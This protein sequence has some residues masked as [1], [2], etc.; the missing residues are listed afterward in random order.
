MLVKCLVFNGQRGF[1]RLA[2]PILQ[3]ILSV[4]WRQ[5]HF[6]FREYLREVVAL[7]YRKQQLSGLKAMGSRIVICIN[8]FPLVLAVESVGHKGFSAALG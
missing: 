3:I 5:V 2:L 6:Q 4:L 7:S 1:R 8:N